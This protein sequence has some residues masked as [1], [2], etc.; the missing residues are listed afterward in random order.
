MLYSSGWHFGNKNVLNKKCGKSRYVLKCKDAVFYTAQ[1]IF[2]FL[3]F[4]YLALFPFLWSCNCCGCGYVC[5]NLQSHI[6]ILH[7]V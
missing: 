3:V 5:C 6:V 2:R 1:P 7:H 4:R